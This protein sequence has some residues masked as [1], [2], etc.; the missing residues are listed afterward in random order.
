[1]V[2][3]RSEMLT[4]PMELPENFKKVP[5]CSEK[6]MIAML[7]FETAGETNVFGAEI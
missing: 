6:R 5:I 2:E 4:G 1:M 7:V 3:V